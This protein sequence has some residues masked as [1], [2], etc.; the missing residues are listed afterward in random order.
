MEKELAEIRAM[1]SEIYIVLIGDPTN[2][3]KP[4]HHT[5]ID[6]LERSNAFKNRVLWVMGTGL[7]VMIVDLIRAAICNH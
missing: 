1:L 6:R 4:G 3:D 2:P 5:R 7:F